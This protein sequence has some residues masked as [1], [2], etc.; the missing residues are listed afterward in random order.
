MQVV[1]IAGASAVHPTK[2]Q[3]HLFTDAIKEVK[4]QAA[5]VPSSQRGQPKQI[6][7]DLQDI[8]DAAARSLTADQTRP[9]P[10][11]ASLQAQA[12]SN[13]SLTSS[14]Q[15][16][17]T[18]AEKNCLTEQ[19]RLHD[20]RRGY[21]SPLAASNQAKSSSMIKVPQ[22]HHGAAASSLTA[23][24]CS[25][26]GHVTKDAAPPQLAQIDPVRPHHSFSDTG[27]YQPLKG[28]AQGLR[29]SAFISLCCG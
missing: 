23:D 1:T 13:L 9:Q 27:Q 25:S 24:I 11:C 10:P 6:S 3:H 2:K 20:S 18:R 7:N 4:Q 26:M 12:N 21:H 15:D 29:V 19:P 14:D 5:Q 8:H 16:T 22:S 28:M 17:V